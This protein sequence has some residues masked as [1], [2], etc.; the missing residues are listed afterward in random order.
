LWGIFFY[1]KISHFLA[2]F[3]EKSTEEWRR[4]EQK[5]RGDKKAR[6][7]EITMFQSLSIVGIW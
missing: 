6:S 2:T 1:P 7:L 5:T 4:T 3:D